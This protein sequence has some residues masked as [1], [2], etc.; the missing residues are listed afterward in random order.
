M[1]QVGL[2]PVQTDTGLTVL[3]SISDLTEH[4][5]QAAALRE[6]NAA[7][8]LS[9]LEL[10]RFAYVASHDLQTPM[11]SIASFAELLSSNYADKLD[12][13]AADWLHR[14]LASI[15]QLRVLVG[16]LLEYSR[17]DTDA[18]PAESVVVEEV[19][20]Q[21]VA[22]LDDAISATG[23]QVTCGTLPTI[24]AHRSQVTELLLHLIDNAIKYHGSEP[25]RVHVSAERVDHEWHFRVADN[26]IGITPKHYERIF[27][28][29]ARLHS[30]RAFPGTGIGLAAC[31]RIVQR[32]G[33]RIW[34][35]SELGKGSV[36]HFTIPEVEQ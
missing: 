23:A 13:R 35:E 18:Q 1:V 31:R 20:T 6:A 24:S 32:H 30:P 28:I 16:D 9:N 3:A 36:F 34:V 17:I 7:L 33:G 22:L 26:G 27:E 19:F 25:P 21:V 12:A 10:E 15:N 29:F 14:I 4:L 11:R 2:S 8:K 5:R